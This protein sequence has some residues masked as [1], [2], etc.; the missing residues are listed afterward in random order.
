MEVV[1][2]AGWEEGQDGRE[3]GEHHL[4]PVSRALGNKEMACASLRLAKY[5][6]FCKTLNVPLS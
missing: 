5:V 4:W 2:N 6:L 1:R 3:G